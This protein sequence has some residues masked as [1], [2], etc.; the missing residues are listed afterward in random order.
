MKFGKIALIV[1]LLLVAYG[2]GAVTVYASKIKAPPSVAEMTV[3]EKYVACLASG[4]T[5]AYI[6]VTD[7]HS[8]ECTVVAIDDHDFNLQRG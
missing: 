8:Y 7:A 2:L 6:G 5:F 1:A 3:D 4:G